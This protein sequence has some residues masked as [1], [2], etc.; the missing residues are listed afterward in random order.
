MIMVLLFVLLVLFGLFVFDCYCVYV[1]DV[2]IVYMLLS[3]VVLCVLFV[4]Y[5]LFY[6][7]VYVVVFA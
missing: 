1:F 3:C 5:P 4:C 7:F 6:R 2:S